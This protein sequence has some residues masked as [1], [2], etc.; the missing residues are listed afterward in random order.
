M[1]DDPFK[2]CRSPLK[3]QVRRSQGRIPRDRRPW[4]L[5]QFCGYKSRLW[6]LLSENS[7]RT[8]GFVLTRNSEIMY[9]TE[10]EGDGCFQKGFDRCVKGTIHALLSSLRTTAGQPAA[11]ALWSLREEGLDSGAVFHRQ[12]RGGE[13]REKRPGAVA[14]E[15]DAC[16]ARFGREDGSDAETGAEKRAVVSSR[17]RDGA[18]L[19]ERGTSVPRYVTYVEDVHC[20]IRRAGD[21]SP[22]VRDAHAMRSCRDF[23]SCRKPTYRGTDVPRSPLPGK[24]RSADGRQGFAHRPQRL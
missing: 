23:M 22:P 13:A 20:A 7:A 4:A 16:V 17:R 18:R 10:R 21:V 5:R 3:A 14:E 12:R 2:V 1:R 15:G 6:E 11:G 19:G 24:K 9:I 8:G